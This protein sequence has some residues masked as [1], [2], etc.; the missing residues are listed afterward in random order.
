MKAGQKIKLRALEP[1][2]VDLLYEWENDQRIWHISN[3]I[4]PLSRFVLEQYVLNSHLDIF[5]TRQLRFMIDDSFSGQT[6]GT[7]DLFDFEPMHR[8][9]GIG[10]FILESERNKGKASEALNLLIDYCFNTLMVNQV[11]CNIT[12]DNSESIQ[13]FTKKGFELIGT[14]KN[15]LLINNHWTDENMYQLIKS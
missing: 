4:A 12:P 11:F 14:R 6:I 5:N 13:L 1:S 2:D 9:V 10:I 3:T 15:W 7:A 8:R